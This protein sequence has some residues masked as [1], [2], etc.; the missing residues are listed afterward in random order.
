M[1]ILILVQLLILCFSA[2]AGHLSISNQSATI[3]HAVNQ[4]STDIFSCEGTDVTKTAICKLVSGK[5][6]EELKKAGI[7][8][9]RNGVLFQ[10]D[11]PKDERL[12]TGHSCT[13][14]ADIRHKQLNA[15]FASSSTINLDRVSLNR[16]LAL[17]LFLPI[18]LNGRIEVKQ[19]FGTR[20]LFG[21]CKSY[22]TDTFS[23]VGR[24][25][26]NA[27]IIIG[28]SLNPVYSKLSSGDLTLKITPSVAILFDLDNTDLK[29]RVSG[30][31][32]FSFVL[33]SVAGIQSTLMKSVSALFKGE[34]VLRV[35]KDGL[36]RD[37][38]LSVFLWI[39][40]LPPQFEDLIGNLLS[41][42]A[43]RLIEKEA[44]GFGPDL[45]VDI[46]GKI[47]QALGMGSSISRT[48]IIKKD[49]INL[50]GLGK[51]VDE[52]ISG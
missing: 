26:T 15:L 9:E 10:Y 12:N 52:I 27:N 5:I 49:I 48:F 17:R 33:T 28:F 42:P 38:G 41:H 34:N 21:R 18:T 36:F 16:P 11:D 23:L 4:I 1:H 13:V 44:A 24:L 14:T 6:N 22:A 19:K 2:L 47:R 43:E 32:L 29:Y 37:I 39:G 35:L 51:A 7:S 45:E 20:I 50:V 31:D 25:A 8:I 40:T 3:H 30:V 46:L